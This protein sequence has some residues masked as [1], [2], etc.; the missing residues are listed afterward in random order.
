MSVRNL[1]DT[2][3]CIY[4]TKQRPREVASRFERQRPGGVG[5]SMNSCGELFGA[6]KSQQPQP[7]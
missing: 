5:M 2:N 7:A 3:I 4:I 6:E 1:L